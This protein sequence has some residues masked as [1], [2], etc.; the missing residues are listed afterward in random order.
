MLLSDEKHIEIGP[1]STTHVGE[2]EIQRIERE[3]PES[4]LH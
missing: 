1:K 2:Q 3:R 4:R